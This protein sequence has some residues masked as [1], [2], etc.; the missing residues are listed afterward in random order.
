MRQFADL[1]TAVVCSAI[2]AVLAAAAFS[3]DIDGGTG[4][5]ASLGA[6]FFGTLGLALTISVGVKMGLADRVGAS[7][8]V[9]Q[10]SQP[11]PRA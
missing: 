4:L 3:S 9:P 2:A 5:L 8:A 10:E 11:A 1:L 6:A 7:P